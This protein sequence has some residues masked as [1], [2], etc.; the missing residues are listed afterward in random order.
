M[1]C[2]DC[3]LT[4][5]GVAIAGL[6][7]LA[8][9]YVSRRRS[10]VNMRLLQE[11][12]KLL[13]TSMAGLQTIETLKATG[14]ESDFFGRWSGLPGQGDGRRAET[15]CLHALVCGVVPPLLAALN[16]VAILG[17]GSL[18]VMSGTHDHWHAGGLSE[19]DDQFPRPGQRAGRAGRDRC[20]KSKARST[21]STTSCALP[22]PTTN[23]LENPA[24]AAG[25]R[26]PALLPSRCLRVPSS[27]GGSRRRSSLPAASICRT[28]PSATAGWIRR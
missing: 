19:P 17:L 24:A 22:A 11:R 16:T 12:A 23:P 4:A 28:S 9:R 20:R 25:N 26:Q 15:Q 14:A 13:G 8:L 10:D 6:N 3:L 5:V 7:V 1:L 21:A 27:L 2:Y 18:Q